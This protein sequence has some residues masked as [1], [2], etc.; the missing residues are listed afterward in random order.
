M[1][2]RFYMLVLATAVALSGAAVAQKGPPPSSVP[3]PAVTWEPVGLEAFTVENLVFAEGPAPD[4]SLDTLYVVDNVNTRFGEPHPDPERGYHGPHRLPPGGEWSGKLCGPGSGYNCIPNLIEWTASGILLVGHESGPT[5]VN[6]STDGATTWEFNLLDEGV[7]CLY[8]GSADFDH[9]VFVCE[10]NGPVLRS[11]ADGAAGTWERLGF[12]DPDEEGFGAFALAEALPGPALDRPRLVAGVASGMSYSDDGGVTWTRSSLW[13]DFRFWVDGGIAQDPIAGHPYGGVLYAGVID[14]F[15]SYPTVYAS[16]DGGETWEL[17]ATG[18]D[19]TEFRFTRGVVATDTTGGVWYGTSVGSWFSGDSR[20]SVLW[21]GDGA[22]TWANVSEGLPEMG[23]NALL[24]GRDGRLYAGTDQGVWRTA[25]PVYVVSGEPTPPESTDLTLR[26]DPNPTTQHT[27]AR[28][29][30]ARAGA[31]RVSVFDARG[32]EV[33]VL[34]E[35]HRPSGEHSE[36]IATSSLAPG[37]YVVR[38]ASAEGTASAS[39]TVAR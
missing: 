34:A 24:F 25:Q 26:V 9:A 27:A 31:A 20:G 3:P 7:N 30:Q 2:R 36:E 14:Y 21:S 33:L 22:R 18:P 6:R 16:E 23:V 10:D 38:V 12:P 37:V 1:N 28:W 5:K 32:R 11:D 19:M 35:G 4:G 13:Q 15:G 39:F 8:A 17:R 29:R